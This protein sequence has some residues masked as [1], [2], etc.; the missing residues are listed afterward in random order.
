MATLVLLNKPF[1]VLSQFTDDQGRTT[2]A[3]LVH[4]KGVYPAGRLDYDSEGLLLLTADGELQHRIAS[5]THKLPKTYWVLVEGEPAPQ[6]LQLLQRG[7][8]LND[9]PCRPA[10]VKTIA[11][12]RLWAR[13]PPV[14]VRKNIK[15][16]WLEITIT[17]GRNRQVRRMTAAIGH[18]TLR[19]IRVA[20]GPWKLGTLVPGESRKEQVHLPSSGSPRAKTGSNNEQAGAGGPPKNARRPKAGPKKPHTS[21]QRAP[22]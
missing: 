1:N 6:A 21:R 11:P 4:T 9:G 10:K 3:D 8:T 7:V 17:E 20:I 19:L 15:D 14:R 2:L 12:P 18:P 22:R 16:T 13:N 5:P